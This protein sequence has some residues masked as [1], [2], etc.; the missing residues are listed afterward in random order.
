[1]FTFR[2]FTRKPTGKHYPAAFGNSVHFAVCSDGKKT[3]LNQ[4]YGILFAKAKIKEDNTL[5]ERGIRNPLVVKKDDGYVI[6]FM[7]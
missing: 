6:Y 5:D 2:V 4:D 3:V 1:M 7:N